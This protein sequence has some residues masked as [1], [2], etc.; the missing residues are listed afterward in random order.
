[1]NYN[2]KKKKKKKKKKNFSSIFIHAWFTIFSKWVKLNIY[3][4]EP[5]YS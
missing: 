4:N 3:I 1:M 5:V 2:G